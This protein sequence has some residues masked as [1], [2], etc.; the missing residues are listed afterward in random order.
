MERFLELVEDT[1]RTRAQ[2]SAGRGWR[3]GCDRESD[4]APDQ[5]LE[6]TLAGQSA[7]RWLDSHDNHGRQARLQYEH[8]TGVEQHRNRHRGERDQKEL[9]PPG[10]DRSRSQVG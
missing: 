2:G 7:A 1:N 5:Y 3:E 8:A 10:A 9:P 6:K 4:E